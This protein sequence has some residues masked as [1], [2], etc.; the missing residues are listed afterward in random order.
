MSW[1]TFLEGAPPAGHAVQ[2]YSELD[3]LAASSHVPGRRLSGRRACGRDRE[4]RS[5]G[6]IPLELERRG[7]DVD[8]LHE[9]GVLTC[10]DADKTLATFMDGDVPSGERFEETVG[11]L[12]DEVARRFPERTI[13]AFGEMVDL[14]SSAGSRP[15][16]SRSRSSGT[17]H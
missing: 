11:G 10:C 3:E 1:S 9:Q 2:V 16:R 8:A 6:G 4:L 15:P 13:R 12:L 7:H 5:L 14:L 17:A